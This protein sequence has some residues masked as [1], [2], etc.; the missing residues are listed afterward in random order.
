MAHDEV[1]LVLGLPAAAV[2]LAVPVYHTL[3]VPPVLG[4]QGALP[5]PQDAGGGGGAVVRAEHRALQEGFLF[6]DGFKD[7]N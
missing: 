1:H 7:L 3:A 6:S 4:D 2:L 5:G